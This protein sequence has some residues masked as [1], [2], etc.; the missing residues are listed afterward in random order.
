MDTAVYDPT[1]E[2]FSYGSVVSTGA[3]TCINGDCSLPGE[4]NVVGSGCFSSVSLSKVDCDGPNPGSKKTRK[5]LEP[6][7]NYQNARKNSTAGSKKM[8]ARS[9]GNPS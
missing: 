6:L 8:R 5:L 2:L 3:N 7:V 1:T 4:T 9:I